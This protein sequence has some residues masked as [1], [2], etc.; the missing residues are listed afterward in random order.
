[1]K[2]AREGMS[3]TIRSVTAA[4]SPATPARVAAP[5]VLEAAPVDR[6]QLGSSHAP[7]PSAPVAPLQEVPSW[8]WGRKGHEIVPTEAALALPDTMPAFFTKNADRLTALGSQPDRWR[9]KELKHLAG[10]N[11]PD[12]YMNWEPVKEKELPTDR[13]AYARMIQDSDLERGDSG[14]QY[15]GTLPYRMAELF[16]G[17]VAEFALYRMELE[18]TP[19]GGANALLRQLEENA[20]YTAGILSHYV[21]DATQPLHASVHHD[22]WDEKFE[23]N[24]GGFRTKPGVHREFEVFLVNEAVTQEE[25]R[26][27]I[28]P[29]QV[30]EGDP[31]QLGVE[32]VKESN[33]LVKGLYKLES[34]GKLNPW[35]PH[36]EGVELATN[37]LARGAQLLRD[38]WYSA[39]V[40]S[41]AIAKGSSGVQPQQPQQPHDGF[42][43]AR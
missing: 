31:L 4:G 6:V 23:P 29:A 38:L 20:I 17:L 34:E 3:V 18:R 1:M 39:W 24:P 5:A 28:P 42:L 27:R 43:L 2:G 19:D 12:H 26:R 16:E 35:K 11:I 41:E 13:Y 32:L 22:G 21:A 37:R 15:N 8:A 36:P 33:G 25:V 30:F 7:A 14:P 10:A 40:R 9:F